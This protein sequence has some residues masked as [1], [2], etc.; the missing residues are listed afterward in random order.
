[1]GED[2]IIR[3]LKGYNNFLILR[4]SWLIGSVRENFASKILDLHSKEDKIKIISDQI[5]SSTTTY[6]LSK[7]IWEIIKQENKLN[8]GI[9]PIF[10][11]SDDGI[12]S[13]YDLAVAISEFSLELGLIN[14]KVVIEPIKSDFYSNSSL[15]Q[16]FLN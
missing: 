4:T 11:W 12:A 14:K 15:D 3:E 6:S 8:E 5:G 7:V 2:N 13:W 1:M 16:D 9:N 10:H